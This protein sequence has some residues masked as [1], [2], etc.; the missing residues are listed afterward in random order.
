MRHKDRVK[1]TERTILATALIKTIQA[2]PAPIAGVANAFVRLRAPKAF[3]ASVKAANMSVP[4]N[5]AS[6]CRV[7]TSLKTRRV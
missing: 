4:E 7:I 6:R 3:N 5:Y 1:M 2:P